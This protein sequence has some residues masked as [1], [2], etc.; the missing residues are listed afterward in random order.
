MEFAPFS[1]EVLALLFLVAV[2]AGFLDT[3]AGGGGLLSLPALILAGAPPLAALG[4]NKFQS[5]V[6][7]ATAALMMFK[8]GKVAGPRIRP[9]MLTAFAGSALGSVAVQFIGSRTLSVVIPVV[10][11]GIAL[12]FLFSPLPAAGRRAPALAAGRYKNTVTPAI[13]F[14]D[15]MFGPGTGSFYALAGVLCRGQPLI[16]ATAAAKPLNFATN[17]ASLLVFLAA[18]QLIWQ[19]GLGML[20]GQLIGAWLGAHCL[21]RINPAWLRIIIV[22]MCGGMLLRYCLSPH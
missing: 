20:L 8:K 16:E 21:F 13:G 18:G 19:A 12:Y 4:T 17:L 14:Y 6:G 2:I 9:L 11:A 10:L 1:A 5:T 15:G 22:L 7:T 3:L